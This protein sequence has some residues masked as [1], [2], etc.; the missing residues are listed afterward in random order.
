MWLYC[1]LKTGYSIWHVL[2]FHSY[3]FM[4]LSPLTIHGQSC[5][6]FFLCNPMSCSHFLFLLLKWYGT[7]L[8][9]TIKSSVENVHSSMKKNRV[10]LS[11]ILHPHV[12]HAHRTLSLITVSLATFKD[13]KTVI[14]Q[15]PRARRGTVLA[16]LLPESPENNPAT[17]F[18]A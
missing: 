10:S 7:V 5:I 16:L 14:S 9:C 13:T 1:F 3:R 11:C 6:F 18:C 2:F 8:K 17:L 4:I 15:F 12:S